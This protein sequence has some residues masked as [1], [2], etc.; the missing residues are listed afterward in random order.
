MLQCESIMTDGNENGKNSRVNSF[1][2][3]SE[4]KFSAFSMNCIVW[5]L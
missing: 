5:P 3:G 1:P 4:A 2:L